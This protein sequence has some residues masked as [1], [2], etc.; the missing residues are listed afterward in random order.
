MWTWM[1]AT[2]SLVFVG[3]ACGGKKKAD[4]GGENDDKAGEKPVE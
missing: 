4:K 3:L 1:A 2:A